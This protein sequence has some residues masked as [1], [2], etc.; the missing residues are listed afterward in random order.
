MTTQIKMLDDNA[1]VIRVVMAFSSREVVWRC[2]QGC[3][4]VLCVLEYHLGYLILAVICVAILECHQG[5][6]SRIILLEEPL[7]ILFIF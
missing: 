7:P 6:S 3:H 2:C 5:L 4:L 1:S